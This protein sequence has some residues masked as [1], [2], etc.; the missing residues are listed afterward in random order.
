MSQIMYIVYAVDSFGYSI[1]TEQCN[2]RSS[3]GC[4]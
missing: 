2:R 4:W 3:L 1:W